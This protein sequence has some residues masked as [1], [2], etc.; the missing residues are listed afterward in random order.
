MYWNDQ[1]ARL[2][3][4]AQA[5][6][7]A[8]ARVDY[9]RHAEELLAFDAGNHADSMTGGVLDRATRRGDG[10]FTIDGY[11]LDNKGASQ[12]YFAH[13]LTNAWQDGKGQMI[14]QYLPFLP[15]FIRVQAMNFMR[16]PEHTVVTADGVAYPDEVQNLWH[17]IERE[18]RW[19]S[20]WKQI[21]HK[22]CLLKT[23]FAQPAWRSRG[24]HLD[25]LTPNVVDVWQAEDDPGNLAA[26]RVVTTRLPMSV[27]T[28]Y[29]G[30]VERFRVWEKPAPENGNQWTCHVS[31][32]MGR[33][34]PNSL[35]E[36]NINLY[37]MFPIIKLNRT[38]QTGR[39][40]Q[41][42]DDSYLT[43]QVG[44]DLLWTWYH[45]LRPGG[46]A[47]MTTGDDLQDARIPWGAARGVLLKANSGEDFKFEQIQ[48]DP[49]G[50]IG[51]AQGWLKTL[52]ATQGID[53]DA[54]SIDGS[55]FNK[56]ITGLAVQ[57]GRADMSDI[58]Q[59]SEAYLEYRLDDTYRALMR[60]N[61]VHRPTEQLP[62]ESHL[63]TRWSDS[64]PLQNPQ[65]RVNTLQ[66]RINSGIDSGV[67][68]I[69]REKP[70]I[71][72][73]EAMAE[74]LE[75]VRLRDIAGT[76]RQTPDEGGS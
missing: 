71:D 69:I 20:R 46:M 16:A 49:E 17:R 52:A 74:Y 65:N 53:P 9:E 72:Q 4:Q 22:L 43:A 7:K 2:I 14:P 38:E 1:T 63:A 6:A 50:M 21:N 60:V 34:L 70:G 15:R 47:V 45:F 25:I 41:E 64:E 42:L 39:I 3:R 58:L 11:T 19:P 61:N 62:E 12:G 8:L 76:Q 10:T 54:F 48:Y 23:V 75:N 28:P 35:F 27:D 67:A 30:Q 5:R 40:F 68:E 44:L 56:A 37:G 29:A 51:F 36:D 26:A 24:L 13:F 31:D 66:A 32:A 57:M 73:A 59:D 33:P 18:V 55:S